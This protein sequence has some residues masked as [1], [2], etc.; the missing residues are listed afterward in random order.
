[1]A[2][3]QQRNRSPNRAP[4]VV[5]SASNLSTSNSRPIAYGDYIERDFQIREAPKVQVPYNLYDITRTL[6]DNHTVAESALCDYIN[7]TIGQSVTVSKD[8]D[9][10]FLPRVHTIPTSEI[11]RPDCSIVKHN[12]TIFIRTSSLDKQTLGEGVRCGSTPPNLF[13]PLRTSL[14]PSEPL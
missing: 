8:K 9:M 5:S 1:M 13:E 12:A 4:I 3:L 7:T 10:V 6:Y 14:N 11:K 2:I